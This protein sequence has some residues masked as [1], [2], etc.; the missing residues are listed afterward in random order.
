MNSSVCCAGQACVQLACLA[1]DFASAQRQLANAVL[2]L[3]SVSSSASHWPAC[4]TLSVL[5]MS[6]V[7]CP[8][9]AS[10]MPDWYGH[11]VVRVQKGD[12]VVRL[13]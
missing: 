11:V 9:E 6:G 3:E 10:C 12:C 8:C 5:P 7:V 1:P 4:N 2:H 13:S